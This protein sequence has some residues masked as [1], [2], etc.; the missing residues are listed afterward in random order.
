LNKGSDPYDKSYVGGFSINKSFFGK[1][2]DNDTENVFNEKSV[3]IE[4]LGM[5]SSILTLL[6]AQFATDRKQETVLVRDFNLDRF[7]LVS[8]KKVFEN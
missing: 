4:A 1:F 8:S 6:A 7:Y 2:T 3:T 5:S